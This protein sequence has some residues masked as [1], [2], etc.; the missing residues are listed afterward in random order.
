MENTAHE[1][2]G[3]FLTEA[4]QFRLGC[5]LTES[6]HPV[7]RNLSDTAQESTSEALSLLFDVDA[8][9]LAKYREWISTDAPRRISAEVRDALLAGGK[10]FFTGCGS[11]GRLSILM[12]SIWRDFWQKRGDSTWENRTFSVMAG[13]DFALIK[14]VEGFEDFTQFGGKQIGDLGVAK[15]DVVFAITEGGETSF[16]IGTAWKGLEVGA[17]VYFV[18]NNPDPTLTETIIRSREVIEDPRIEKIN[19]ATGP[20]GIMGSTRMQATSIELCITLTIMEM[21]I[22]DITGEGDSS[23]VPQEFMAGLDEIYAS[24]KSPE[25]LDRLAELVEMEET[26]YRSKGK[27]TYFADGLGVDV[28]TDTTERSPTFCTPAFRKWDDT[29]AAESWTY[30]ILPYA[31]SREAWTKLLKHPPVGL[32]WSAEEVERLVGPEKAPRQAE[33]MTQIGPEEILKFKIGL[34]G[35]KYRPFN[36]GDSALAIV[37]SGEKDS[38]LKPGGFF[39]TQLEKAA[40]AGASTGL[41]YAGRREALAEVES[42]V[43]SW[44]I[45]ARYALLPIPKNSFLLDGVARVA[46]KILLNTLSTCIMVRLQRVLGNCMV[47]VVPSNLKLIDRS[48]RYIHTLTGLSYEDSCRMLFE[49]IE[50]VSPRMKAGQ[51]YPPVVALSVVRALHNLSLEDAEAYLQENETITCGLQ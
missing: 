19:L 16:V 17:R 2:A 8:D 27:S 38:L 31:D 23:T 10:W 13:G 18:Y 20:M 43:K 46:V 45:Q 15:G 41:V 51:D 34:D 28:L 48:S 32:T 7:T 37:Y 5:L 44:G 39:R 40:E 30:L 1:Q 33:I 3:K 21:V 42:F 49:A 26:S 25:L 50:Y 6:A 24:L 22:R 12:D 47:A 9:V 35:L 14:A 11:T 4:T 36:P 29:E